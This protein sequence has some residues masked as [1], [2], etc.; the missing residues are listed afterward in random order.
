M[1]CGQCALFVIAY[2]GRRQD[3][4]TKDVAVQSGM[5][6]RCVEPRLALGAE[7]VLVVAG[8]AVRSPS[9]DVIWALVLLPCSSR[10]LNVTV[11]GPLPVTRYV[12]ADP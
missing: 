2:G 1:S 6:Y 10:W 12:A 4:V 8:A 9:V 5:P 7:P 3:A 11:T